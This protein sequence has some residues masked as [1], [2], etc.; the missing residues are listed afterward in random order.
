[1]RIFV[2]Y[3]H[4]QGDWV[5]K[6]LVPI[7]SAS[8]AEV[9]VDV[10][11]FTAGKAVIGQM[12]DLQR[13]AHRHILV[14][15]SDYVASDYCRHEMAQAI[16]VDPKF[17]NGKVIAIRRDDEPL[18]SDLGG[19]GSLGS[20]QLYVDLRDDR[21]ASPWDLLLKSCELE[22]LGV[23]A[24]TWLGALD[25]TER[26][27]E[28]GESVNLVVKNDDVKWRTWFAHLTDVRQIP[29]D[30]VDLEDPKTVARNGLIGAILRETGRS[31]AAVPPPPDD[32]TLLAEAFDH[33][34]R[35]LLALQHFDYVEEREHYGFDLFS[36]L[37]WLVMNQRQLVLLAQTVVPVATLLPPRHKLSEIDFKTVE[38]G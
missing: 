36:S 14:I 20:G 18:P 11:R 10:D 38:L 1:M 2:S 9:L 3:V 12:D 19:N 13:K 15:T 28:R 24:P 5:H 32:M 33:G 16:A 21:E 25:Q 7:L 29:L 6:H 37:R 31:N 22:P 34:A 26:H 35:S 8:G 30:I 23:S 4:K 17:S 27:L